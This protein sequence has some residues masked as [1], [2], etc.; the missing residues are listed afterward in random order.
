MHLIATRAI[1]EMH[2]NLAF[3]IDLSL[4][5]YITSLSPLHSWVT[6]RQSE[7]PSAVRGEVERKIRPLWWPKKKK[8][9]YEG[10]PSF[11]CNAREKKKVSPVLWRDKLCVFRGSYGL[12]FFFFYLRFVRNAFLLFC[13][14]SG[15]CR[16]W[17]VRFSRK[18]NNAFL[19][20]YDSRARNVRVQRGGLA[21]FVSHASGQ[22]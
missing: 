12:T 16:S 2:Y 20:P 4:F 1:S 8:K 17:D 13:D 10:N 9:Y 14:N 5:Y 15:L 11:V 3:C 7:N 21:A 19:F 22:P 6:D 18:R